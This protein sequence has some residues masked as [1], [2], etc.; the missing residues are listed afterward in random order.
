MVF[1]GFGPSVKRC[2]GSSW[3]MALDCVLVFTLGVTPMYWFWGWRWY[4]GFGRNIA[5]T[6][7]SHPLVTLSDTARNSDMT[8]A[9]A[10]SQ[11]WKLFFFK[12]MLGRPCPLLTIV[13]LSFLAPLLVRSTPLVLFRSARTSWNTFVHPP[14]RLFACSPVRLFT[15]AKNLIRP[16]KAL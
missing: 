4:W 14:V 8:L 10:P 5:S 12:S 3:S 15:S 16:C 11:P 7:L 2:D 1:N 6:Y 9:I 13:Y